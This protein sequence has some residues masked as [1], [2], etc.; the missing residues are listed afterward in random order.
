MFCLV[1]AKPS[2]ASLVVL[3]CTPAASAGLV[4]ILVLNFSILL[5]ELELIQFLEKLFK[6]DHAIRA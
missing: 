1:V 5:L 6:L 2:E 4:G 3:T